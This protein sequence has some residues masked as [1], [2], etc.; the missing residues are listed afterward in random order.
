MYAEYTFTKHTPINVYNIE[1]NLLER[2]I[3]SKNISLHTLYTIFHQMW[4]LL[5]QSK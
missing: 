2:K 5:Q 4:A 3:N 1:I